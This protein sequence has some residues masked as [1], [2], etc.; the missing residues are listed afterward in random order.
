MVACRLFVKFSTMQNAATFTREEIGSL[1]DDDDDTAYDARAREVVG[2]FRAARRIVPGLGHP[3]HVQGDPR[4]P[5]LRRI[6]GEN[7]FD[8]RHWRFMT[9]VEAAAREEYGRLLPINAAGAVGATVTDMGL[10]PIWARAF[11]LIGR[12]AGLLA[13]LMEE[14]ENPQGQKIRDMILEQ[15]DS[16]E[17]AGIAAP[18]RAQAIRLRARA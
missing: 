2:A 15:D 1:T 7:G 8:G 16:A 17:L 4:T 12:S 10:A 14:R 13:H 11:A 9:A 6:A 18:A 3:I 5:V